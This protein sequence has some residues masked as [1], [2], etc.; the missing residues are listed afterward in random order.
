MTV[1]MGIENFI[2]HIETETGNKLSEEDKK[3]LYKKGFE[4]F[5]IYYIDNQVQV[6]LATYEDREKLKNYFEEVQ[7]CF[8]SMFA[9]IMLLEYKLHV[10]FDKP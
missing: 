6:N 7:D 1:E 4:I 8:G 10:I 5:D 2:D 9:H 3:W